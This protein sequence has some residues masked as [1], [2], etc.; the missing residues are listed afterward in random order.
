M[1]SSFAELAGATTAMVLPGTSACGLRGFGMGVGGKKEV[2][3][4]PVKRRRNQS[5]RCCP[6]R[7]EAIAIPRIDL[8]RASLL[9]S[10]ATLSRQR[11]GGCQP[12]ATPGYGHTFFFRPE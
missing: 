6:N 5:I 2:Y 3:N 12:E 7:Y 8:G 9:E 1:R 4:G 10:H 11:R